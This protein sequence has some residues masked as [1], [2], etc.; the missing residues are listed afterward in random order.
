MAPAAESNIYLIVGL[1]NPGRRYQSTRHNAGFMVIDRIAQRLPSGTARSRFQAEFRETTDGGARV[2]LAKPRT[3]M[4]DSGIAVAQLMRWFKVPRERLLIVYDELDLP[5]GTLRL[6][7][8]GSDG[9]HNGMKSII[10]HVRTQDFA[11][12]RVGIS[13]PPAGAT[14][15]YVLASFHDAE[16]RELPTVLERAADAALVWRREGVVAAM[17][18]FNRREPDGAGAARQAREPGL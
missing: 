3:F 10:Q 7:A 2:V 18:D 5:F 13:R 11:R 6:R 14:V 4:N 12:L 16:R 8:D 9:G 17:N 1:G 15:P